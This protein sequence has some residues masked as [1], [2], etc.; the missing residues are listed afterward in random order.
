MNIQPIP[1]RY[2]GCHFRS[3]LEAR[4]AVLF[5]K[6]GIRWLYEPQGFDIR[7]TWYLPDFYL[8]QHKL[9]V[10]V[11]GSDDGFDMPLAVDAAIP[12]WGLPL[13]PDGTPV[14]DPSRAGFRLLILGPIPQVELEPGHFKDDPD[15]PFW[16]WPTH[17]AL[18][19]W[20]GDVTAGHASFTRPGHIDLMDSGFVLGNDAGDVTKFEDGSYPKVTHT[21]VAIW[22]KSIA[23]QEAAGAYRAARSARFEHGESG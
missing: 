14:P 23:T 2:A 16:S 21:G 17:T 11:K 6:L 1:T 20:K 18:H 15:T 3:R 4:Y 8:P 10:E 22:D 7:G 19:Y 5:D 12:A 13:D 9:W